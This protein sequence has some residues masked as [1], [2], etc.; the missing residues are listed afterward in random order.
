MPCPP[1][2]G[3]GVVAATFLASYP[4]TTPPSRYTSDH[5]CN[6]G[7]NTSHLTVDPYR[8]D[9]THDGWSN[10]LHHSTS[11]RFERVVLQHAISR[12]SERPF[13]CRP[14]GAFGALDTARPTV[15][16]GTLGHHV[17]LPTT[18]RPTNLSRHP[19]GVGALY[20]PSDILVCV[21]TARDLDTRSLL[22][23]LPGAEVALSQSSRRRRLARR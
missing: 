22:A 13:R 6:G 1:R 3:V 16:L 14:L 23:C 10:A 2:R 7:N 9:P 5:S 18:H 12:L 15:P 8:R 17:T 20:I 19:N 11:Q 4:P 21:C